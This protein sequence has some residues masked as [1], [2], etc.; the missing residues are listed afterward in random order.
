MSSKV[1]HPDH[2]GGADNPYECIKVTEAWGLGFADGCIV[3]YLCRW[4]DKGGIEDLDKMQWYVNWFVR[5]QKINF[6]NDKKQ[7]APV[8]TTAR[9]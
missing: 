2:Y 8:T 4:K 5:Q 7:A 6:A 9:G 1:D 3:K